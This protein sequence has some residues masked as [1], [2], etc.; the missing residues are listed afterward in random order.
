[1]QVKE[2]AFNKMKHNDIDILSKEL[3]QYGQITKKFDIEDES[4]IE[5]IR[6]IKFKGKAYLHYMYNGEVI[7]IT[8]I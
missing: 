5:T 1:M 3:M 2:G 7:E 6:I 4:G 8:E